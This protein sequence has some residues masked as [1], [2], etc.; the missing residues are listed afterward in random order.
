MKND[1]KGETSKT[2]TTTSTTQKK[3]SSGFAFV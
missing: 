1:K 3:G 2:V